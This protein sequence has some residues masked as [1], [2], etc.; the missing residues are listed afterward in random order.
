MKKNIL[1]FAFIAIVSMAF[2]NTSS[3]VTT[4]ICFKYSLTD[5]CSG[6]WSGYYV[7]R[8]SVWQSGTK[9]CTHDFLVLNLNDTKGW[10]CEGLTIDLAHP[11]YAIEIEA[12]RY[13]TPPSCTGHN[14]SGAIYYTDLTSCNTA[15][16]VTLQ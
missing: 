5:N 9:V 16:S 7:L 6:T 14:G 10:D 3:A 13:Q 15:I 11:V 4:S 2:T 1:M 12:W 8:V